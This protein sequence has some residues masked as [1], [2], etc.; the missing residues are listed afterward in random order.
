LIISLFEHFVLLFGFW[1]L[2]FGIFF[3]RGEVSYK[4]GRWLR[5]ANLI[6]LETEHS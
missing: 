4:R 2:E 1:C 5:A 3:E 6:E